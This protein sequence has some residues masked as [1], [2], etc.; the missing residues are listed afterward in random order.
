MSCSG[1]VVF[2][3]QRAVAHTWRGFWTW[4]YLW[5]EDD[6]AS[7]RF[8]P[9]LHESWRYVLLNLFYC[10]YLYLDLAMG[11]REFVMCIRAGVEGSGR[12]LKHTTVVK[13]LKAIVTHVSFHLFWYFEMILMLFLKGDP[14]FRMLFEYGINK[15]GWKKKGTLCFY[16]TKASGIF[17]SIYFYCFLVGVCIW[18]M[19]IS[20]E[21][22]KLAN[23]LSNPLPID[24][25]LAA[26]IPL[27][28]WSTSPLMTPTK[29]FPFNPHCRQFI[30]A[31]F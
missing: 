25:L 13:K 3:W 26:P 6:R 28:T 29:Y 7:H 12:V 5:S 23:L 19:K 11:K 20:C 2:H 14:Q 9:Y 24:P 10:I 16:D 4:R 22:R 30:N 8:V 1:E 15:F 18:F 17:I 31:S 27:S 21:W